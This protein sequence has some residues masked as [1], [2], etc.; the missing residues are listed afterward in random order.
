M[1]DLQIHYF[2]T[3]THCLNFTEA[4]RQLYISQPALSQ[5]I[6]ALE[7]ELNMQLFVRL[8]KRVYLTPAAL[9]LLEELP[10]YEQHYSDIINKARLAAQ[11]HTQNLRIGFMEGQ[12]LP[13]ICLQNFFDFKEKYPNVGIDSSSYSLGELTAALLE[14][15]IDI[16]Y[17][18]S[19][20]VQDKPN[21]LSVD[22][23]ANEGVAFV[24]KNH[25]A[26]HKHISS[27][28]QLRHETFITLQKSES[29]ALYS[30]FM[31][32]CKRA[33]FVPNVRYVP[34]LNDNLLYAELGLGIGIA[35]RQSYACHNPNLVVLEDL[36]IEI[37]KFV[38]AWKKSNMN[39]AIPLFVEAYQ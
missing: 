4:A 15:K 8:K 14:D 13:E 31:N 16:A 24:S 26:A 2:L 3:A 28:K 23:C 7:K 35:N 17:M 30:K 34:S 29:D 27:L 20:D 12:V 39:A 22:V 1:T 38:Y 36:P 25:P 21:L 9:V 33:G 37:N 19:F 11:G 10:K 32:D 18:L 5:Q 6:A